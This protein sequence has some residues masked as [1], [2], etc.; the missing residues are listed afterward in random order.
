MSWYETEQGELEWISACHEI[1]HK[2]MLLPGYS[3]YLE[4]HQRMGIYCEARVGG[5]PHGEA[6]HKAMST[7]RGDLPHIV[8]EVAND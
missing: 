1:R 5:L 2:T 8:F 4:V 7:L 6:M 3:T